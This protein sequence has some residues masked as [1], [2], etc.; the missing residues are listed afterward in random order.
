MQ[1]NFGFSFTDAD[2]YEKL[3]NTSTPLKVIQGTPWYT[4]ISNLLYKFRF[5]YVSAATDERY[6]L[7]ED[8]LPEKKGEKSEKEI[9]ER[10]KIIE[11]Q[12]DMAMILLYL[13]YIPDSVIKGLSS[14]EPGWQ[15]KFKQGMD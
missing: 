4:P 5:Q 7:I 13:A 14:F 10:R 9:L 8:G 11:E 3:D 2:T 12:S 6:N 1:N 15:V